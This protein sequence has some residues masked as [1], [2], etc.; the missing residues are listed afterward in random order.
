MDGQWSGPG[1]PHSPL[2]SIDLGFS[3]LG[4]PFWIGPL[5]DTW[6]SLRFLWSYLSSCQP[7][8]DMSRSEVKEGGESTESEYVGIGFITYSFG[9]LHRVNTIF[10]P[11]SH[12]PSLH[13]TCPS[14]FYRPIYILLTHVY[15]H[16]YIHVCTRV[17]T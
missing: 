1:I 9:H 16:I 17:H 6:N 4:Y 11:P 15:T 3:L 13:Q 5:L 8:Y 7:P 14:V 12:V 10:Y 2:S